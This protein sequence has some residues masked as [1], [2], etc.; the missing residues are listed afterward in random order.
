LAKKGSQPLDSMS[1]YW[2]SLDLEEGGRE[3]VPF[4]EEEKGREER[5]N[6]QSRPS[7]ARPP[8]RKAARYISGGGRRE[9]KAVLG[10]SFKGKR[11]K[12]KKRGTTFS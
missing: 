4:L 1:V 8:V 10:F 5:K 7:S 3:C 11:L 6:G 12:K 9:K 2:S